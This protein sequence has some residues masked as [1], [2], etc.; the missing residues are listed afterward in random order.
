[1]GLKSLFMQRA[2][3][4]VSQ[5][6]T[7]HQHAMMILTCHGALSLRPQVVFYDANGRQLQAFDF[8]TDDAAR[9]LSC[10]AMNPS[11]DTAVV[12][13]Y[14]RLYVFSLNNSTGVWQHMAVKQV[15]VQMPL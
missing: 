9:D 15:C 1:M 8:S 12:G 4:L 5:H 7:A 10:C 2:G 6:A 14:N 11:N 3:P 13:A